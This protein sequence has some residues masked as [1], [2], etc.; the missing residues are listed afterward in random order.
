MKDFNVKEWKHTENKILVHGETYEEHKRGDI[1]VV[2][3]PEC[4]SPD[5]FTLDEEFIDDENLDSCKTFWAEYGCKM[6][7]AKFLGRFK[8]KKANFL[9]RFKKKELSKYVYL[10]LF[11]VGYVSFLI[12]LTLILKKFFEA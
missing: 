10:G 8:K 1:F 3:C 9:R 2:F 6:C 7:K 12:W 5:V 4:G 11:I